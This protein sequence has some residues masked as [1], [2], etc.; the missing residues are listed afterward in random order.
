MV[1][2]GNFNNLLAFY[3][4]GSRRLGIRLEVPCPRPEPSLADLD[5][6]THQNW[7][8]KR[9][10]IVLRKQI[11]TGNFGT[12]YYAKYKRKEQVAVKTLKEGVMDINDFMTEAS[13][14][15]GLRHKNIIQLY[16]VCTTKLPIFIVTEYVSGGSLLNFLVEQIK[17][18]ILS[19]QQLIHMAAQVSAG[20][21]YLESI[22]LVHRDL[23][24]RNVLVG[25]NRILKICDFGLARVIQGEYISQRN[26]NMPFRWMALEWLND[27]RYS[28][29]SDVW[30]FGIL[31]ME[32]FTYG[33]RPYK[34]F[35]DAS[36]LIIKLNDGYRMPKP[37]RHHLP[38]DIYDLIFKCWQRDPEH[39]PTFEFLSN[40][41]RTAI[42][43]R[44]EY[45]EE[46]DLL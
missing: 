5:P 25:K 13:V 20:M 21:Q 17:I 15:K 30:S 12:V 43:D 39:R 4:T 24:A 16:G 28:I 6:E 45:N 3:F 14:M 31:M 40:F 32:I 7:E 18:S 33:E 46:D 23:A 22:D 26:I 29:K 38:N 44:S 8:L 2:V 35:T 42:S 37:E 36:S 34:E 1:K 9:E 27:G 19:F 10:D 11:A 41:L